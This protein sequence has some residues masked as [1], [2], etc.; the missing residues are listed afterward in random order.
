MK[1]IIDNITEYLIKRK[2][3]N[4]KIDIDKVNNTKEKNFARVL[5]TLRENK[6]MVI[7]KEDGIYIRLAGD[8]KNGEHNQKDFVKV[9]D[10]Q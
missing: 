4:N 7:T 2:L 6:V 3:K 9:L 10:F 5:N 8:I 1:K